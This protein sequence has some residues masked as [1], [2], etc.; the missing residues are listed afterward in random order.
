[1]PL[2]TTWTNL[3]VSEGTARLRSLAM[4]ARLLCGPQADRLNA[5]L[6]RAETDTAALV[7]AD[8]ELGRLPTLSM[9]QLLS[10]FLGTLRTGR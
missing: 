9:R 8:A 7:D 3:D 2:L 1:M 10:A 6:H 4:G 5:A